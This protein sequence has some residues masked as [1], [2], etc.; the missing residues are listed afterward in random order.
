MGGSGGI[1]AY[2]R[3]MDFAHRLRPFAL[4]AVLASSCIAHGA[5]AAECMPRIESGWLRLPPGGMP[6]LAGFARI[7]NP[8]GAPAVVTGA[9]S[10]RFEDVSL[11]ETRIVDGVSRM[12]AVRRLTVPVRGS[13][14][15]QPGGLHL[16]LMGPHPAVQPGERIEIELLLDDGRVLRG[17]LPVRSAGG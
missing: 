1:R 17:D 13:V 10:A 4:T 8:C 6:M 14:S 12:R 7:A 9:R 15:L 16:M 3:H 11:H 5:D 2:D